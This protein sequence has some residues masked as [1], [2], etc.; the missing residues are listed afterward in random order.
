MCWCILLLESQH[1]LHWQ[2]SLHQQHFSILLPVDFDARFNKNE[3]YINEYQYRNGD[4]T[5]LLKVGC[6][7]RRQL[8][9]TARC[10]VATGV[11]Y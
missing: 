4:L 11:S 8:A 2:Q 3:I 10:L 7:R 9:L 6:M 5:D 1:V